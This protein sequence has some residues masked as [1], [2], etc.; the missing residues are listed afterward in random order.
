MTDEQIAVPVRLS[1]A[2]EGDVY[3]GVIEDEAGAR[4]GRF[5]A[6]W[7]GGCT[8]WLADG[9]SAHSSASSMAEVLRGLGLHGAV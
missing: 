1:G 9:R 6:E 5:R 8:V 2:G 7:P 4:I 3:A